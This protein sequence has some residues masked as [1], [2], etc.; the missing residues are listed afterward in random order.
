MELVSPCGGSDFV[1]DTLI[2]TIQVNPVGTTFLHGFTCSL[3]C[4]PVSVGGRPF[5]E[6]SV[7]ITLSAN[8]RFVSR[9]IG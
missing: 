8:I 9:G 1:E 4:P 6:N 5:L 7:Q 3:T 2:I